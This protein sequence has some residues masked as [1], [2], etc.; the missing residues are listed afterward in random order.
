MQAPAR[1]DGFHMITR[2]Q[3]LGYRCL[4]YVDQQVA[5]FQVL[6]GANASGKTTFLDVVGFLGDLVGDGLDYAVSCRTSSFQDLVWSRQAPG[7]ELAIEVEIPSHLFQGSAGSVRGRTVRYEVGVA[8]RQSTQS[9]EIIHER[10]MLVGESPLH[11]R[12][13]EAADFPVEAE[14][15][16]T[17][18]LDGSNK[19]CLLIDKVVGEGDFYF[20]DAGPQSG[21]KDWTASFRLGPRRSALGGAPADS[22]R[23]GIALWLRE[24][25]TEGVQSFVLNSLLIRRASPPGQGPG[26]KTDGSNLP[27]VVD[28]LLASSRDRYDMW[29]DHLKSALPDLAGVRVVERAD[30]KHKYL[31][32]RYETGLEVPSW[33]ASDGTL[34]LLALT[35]PA[36]LPQFTGVYLIEEPENGVHP[37]AIE[38]LFQSL[39][40]VYGAQILM[41]THSPVIL[42]HVEPRDVLCFAKTPE[43][44]TDVVRGDRHP[45]L[46]DWRSESDLGLLLAGGVLG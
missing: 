36:Y 23:L 43:G 44:Q 14:A 7:F 19:F 27:W 28:S 46:R 1:K 24:L 34:R 25:L 20:S 29:I 38:T 30:D 32:L 21:E 11:S 10:V 5:P 2:I 31:M 16:E 9:I 4:K 15:P 35:L 42:S 22:S 3:A 33:M 12:H 26:F 37:R 45:A 8:L 6:V 18:F 17:I 40:S 41:A 13:A 39:R